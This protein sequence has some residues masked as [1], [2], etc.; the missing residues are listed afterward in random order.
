M[1]SQLWDLLKSSTLIQGLVTLCLVVTFCIMVSTGR[2][3]SPEFLTI[4]GTVVGFWFGQ[5][6]QQQINSNAMKGL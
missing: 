2:I 3:V 6:S 5:K 1:M 4:L